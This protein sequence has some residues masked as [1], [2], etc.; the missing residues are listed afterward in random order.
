MGIGCCNM[1][2]YY[3]LAVLHRELGHVNSQTL[4]GNARS[5]G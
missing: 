2:D 1:G 5:V 3:A 4:R